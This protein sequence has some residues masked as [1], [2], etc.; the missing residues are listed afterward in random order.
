MLSNWL[1]SVKNNNVS[2]YDTMIG[3]N[4]QEIST[5]GMDR[6]ANR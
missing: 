3:N 5:Q 4:G 2:L 6:F 1:S